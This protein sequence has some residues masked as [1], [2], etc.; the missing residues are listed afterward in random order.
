MVVNITGTVGANKKF[1]FRLRSTVV[2]QCNRS[3]KNGVKF[4]LRKRSMHC[5]YGFQT[6]KVLERL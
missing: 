3:S 6:V 1:T 5:L 4:L 2:L